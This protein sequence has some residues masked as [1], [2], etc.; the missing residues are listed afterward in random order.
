MLT[1]SE[2][3]NMR[4]APDEHLVNL[5]GPVIKEVPYEKKPEHVKLTSSISSTLKSK[6]ART[7]MNTEES[8]PH[9]TRV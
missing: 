2:V 1:D 6:P 8:N 5:E 9:T 7:S 4:R 3:E